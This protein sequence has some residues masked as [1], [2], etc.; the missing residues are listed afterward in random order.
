MSH[1]LRLRHRI[2]RY[3]A[4]RDNLSAGLLICWMITM[5]SLPIAVWIGGADVI[6]IGINIAAV[7]QAAAVLVMLR[8]EWDWRRAG[9][10]LIIVGAVGWA[11]EF[12]GH[13]TGF[14]FG[15]YSYT[16]LLQPQIGG[17]PLLIPA[18]WFMLLPPVWAIA[19]RIVRDH[20]KTLKHR[21]A[22]ITI[23]AAALTAWD[24]FLDPQM[25]GWGFWVWDNPSGYFGIPWSNYAGWLLVAATITLL[26]NPAPLQLFPLAWVYGL[27]WFF[28][29]IGQAVF[30]GQ[31]GPAVVGCVAM[32]S[33][34]LLAYLR[35][36][37]TTHERN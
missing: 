23:S 15:S 19:Q 8:G 6:P 34:M 29:T 5:I 17:V 28:Q 32:G 27:V 9:A 22:F 21:V 18:A 36:S 2:T 1:I 14:P 12:M 20:R 24:L 35:S 31:V 3:A 11:A 25:V 7:F 16:D 30:W 33:V 13:R 10:T 26:V 4:P 37:K